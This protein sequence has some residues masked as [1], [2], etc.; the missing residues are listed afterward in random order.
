MSLP[1]NE[2][3]QAKTETNSLPLRTQAAVENREAGRCV[4]GVQV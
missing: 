1:L 4:R 2:G 3:R